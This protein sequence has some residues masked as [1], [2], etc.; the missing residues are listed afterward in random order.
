[1]AN[2]L[3]LTAFYEQDD[4]DDVL[5][6]HNAAL[7]QLNISAPRDQTPTES[8]SSPFMHQH[9]DHD[10]LQLP[11]EGALPYLDTR[12]GNLPPEIKRQ[13]FG[14]IVGFKNVVDVTIPRAKGGRVRL[15][16]SKMFR[17]LK[18]EF[19]TS[20]L[21]CK[22]FR[23]EV[24]DYLSSTTRFFSTHATSVRNLPTVFGAEAMGLIQRFDL[25][26]DFLTKTSHE[27]TWPHILGMLVG[28]MPNLDR[29]RLLS[30]HEANAGPYPL[31]ETF[32]SALVPR[33]GQEQ[34]VGL[35]FGAFLTLRHPKLK[36]MVLPAES[37]P[38]H[39]TT[40]ARVSYSVELYG[41]G[42]KRPSRKCMKKATPD[43]TERTEHVD[44]VMNSTAIRRIEWTALGNTDPRTLALPSDAATSEAAESDD[45]RYF[46]RYVDRK[47]YLTFL[48]LRQKQLGPWQHMDDLLEQAQRMRDRAAQSPGQHGQA[49]GY[50]GPGG[51]RGSRGG[52]HWRGRGRGSVRDR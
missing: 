50:R 14:H 37:G 10:S 38:D 40:K 1:M 32:D 34:R 16:F 48:A 35:R 24:L 5:D 26:T 11:T 29:F 23:A 27:Q 19:S 36:I 45:D 31:S 39:G 51:A 52:G 3:D 44:L 6:E 9:V 30:N 17:Y 7:A 47:A 2:I 18:M 46:F 8:Q 4:A 13:I 25:N 15:H 20:L 12:P 42:I 28:S 43:A 41:A 21:T 49:T 22:G 33:Y